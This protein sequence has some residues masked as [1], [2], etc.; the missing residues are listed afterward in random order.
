MMNMRELEKKARIID[1]KIGKY[2]RIWRQFEDAYLIR[3]IMVPESESV[4]ERVNV[5]TFMELFLNEA[6]F[7][8]LRSVITVL[9]T[10]PLSGTRHMFKIER[11]SRRNYCDD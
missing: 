7:N 10:Q 11:V 3:D 4:W 9:Y 1:W 8:E 5:N 2:T 6:M